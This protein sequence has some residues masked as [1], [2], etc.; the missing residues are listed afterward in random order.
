MFAKVIPL[1]I[2]LFLVNLVPSDIIRVEDTCCGHKEKSC[3]GTPSEG[4]MGL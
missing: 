3:S 1:L 4:K 2:K